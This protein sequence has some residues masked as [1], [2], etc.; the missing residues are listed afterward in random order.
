MIS[1]LI[2]NLTLDQNTTESGS[3][4]GPGGSV[5][6]M[7]R[8]LKNFKDSSII[9]S[10]IGSDFPKDALLGIKRIGPDTSKHPLTF[11]NVMHADGSR[12]QK[13]F[14]S[15][16]GYYPDYVNESL[17]EPDSI[18][19][20]PVVDA[21]SPLVI[22]QLRKQYSKIPFLWEPQGY[23]RL[24]H[25]DGSITNNVPDPK[26]MPL[27]KGDTVIWSEKDYPNAFEKSLQWSLFGV[28][29]IMTQAQKGCLL[30]EKGKSVSIGATKVGSIVDSTGAGDIFA[31]SYLHGLSQKMSV[32]SSCRFAHASAGFSLRFMP[33]ELQYTKEDVAAFA[34][35]QGYAIRLT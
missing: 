17:G 1:L 21:I 24:V 4:Q 3:Y 18:V 5:Y 23:F 34:K 20:A 7:A 28:R 13:A 2:G 22:K 10:P 15:K 11:Q 6:F 8:T 29:V 33:N 26:R 12:T 27:E 32:E 19:I 16:D 35:S 25:S 30:F 14:L 31:A 9:Y